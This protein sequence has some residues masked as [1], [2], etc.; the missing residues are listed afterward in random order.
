MSPYDENIL[1]VRAM[2]LKKQPGVSYRFSVQ[3]VD[4][5]GRLAGQKALVQDIAAENIHDGTVDEKL[6][7]L[8]VVL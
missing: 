2:G 4:E 8:V 6:N 5:Q 3:Y 7:V 1:P